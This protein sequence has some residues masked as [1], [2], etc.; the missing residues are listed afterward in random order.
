MKQKLAYLCG[1]MSWGGLEMNHLKCAL[2]MQERQHSVVILCRKG[3]PLYTTAKKAGIEVLPIKKHKKY[4]DIPAAIRLKRIIRQEGI[5]HVLLRDTR[6]ISLSVLAKRLSFRPFHLSYF[7]AMQLGVSKRD[8]LHTIRYKGLDLWSCPLEGLANQ[9]KVRTRMS[10]DR[11][12]VIP[13][14][15]VLSDYIEKDPINCRKQLDLPTGGTILGLIGRFDQGKGQDLLLKAFNMLQSTP[16]LYVCLLGE[17]TKG[18]G[19]SEGKTYYEELLEFIR[20]NHLE[21][22]IF[23][24]PFRQDVE[25]FYHAIDA[26]VMASKAET[27]GMVTIEAMASGKPVIASNAGG[28]PELLEYG[29]SGYLFESMNAESLAATISQWLENKNRIPKDV[30]RN[31]V[32]KFDHQL[33]CSIVE[34]ALSLENNNN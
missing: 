25:V 33:S 1:S 27:F 8:L 11:I 22:R 18:D 31:A 15:I 7:M 29:K 5:T 10:H 4:Y 23:I 17:P 30:I 3:S 12:Q 32:Q 21:N 20:K 6:D 24:R 34:Q 26:L 14:G 13:D 19:E 28:S 2:W 16:N 9:V